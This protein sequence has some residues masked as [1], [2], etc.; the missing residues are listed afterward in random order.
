M[1]AENEI[2]NIILPTAD[3]TIF[4]FGE[5]PAAGMCKKLPY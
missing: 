2:E 4:H 1:V 3:V 5:M